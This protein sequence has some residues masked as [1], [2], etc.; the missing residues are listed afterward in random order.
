VPSSSKHEPIMDHEAVVIGA[1]PAGLFSALELAKRKH[2]V[3]ILEEHGKVGEPDHC[4][5]LLSTTGLDRL[6]IH[7]PSHIIQNTVS[8]AKIYSPSGHSIQIERGRNE[9]KVIDRRK[10]DKWLAERAEDV[11]ATITTGARVIELQNQGNTVDSIRIRSERMDQLSAK[12]FIIA[13]GHRCQLSKSVGLPIVKKSY[14]YPAYQY[15]VAG[16]DIDDKIVEMFYGQNIAPGFFAWI[17]PLG[18]RRARIGLAARNKSRP[19]LDNLIQHHPIISE[20]MRGVKIERSMGGVVLIGLPIKK[21]VTGNV[22]VV[23]DTAGVVKATTGGGV[24]L[25]GLT[26]RLAGKMAA[27]ALSTEDLITTL[28]KYD[29]Q[30]KALIGRELRVMY[31]AQHALSS[32]SDKGLDSIIKDA[33]DSGAL[34]IVK[35]A[36][37]MDFQGKVIRGLLKDPRMF[38]IGLRAIR[39]INPFL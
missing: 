3:R 29:R 16:I 30:C 37:D 1:G 12:I 27:D 24:I 13:E 15:E 11:G 14:R 2:D 5:G 23:G 20:R 21:M 34:D 31:L 36:G 18:D 33:G 8:G 28:G 25:G 9:A 7:M 17:I 38:L 22:L 35:D 4:A 6:G 32:L 39:Y 19:R 26:S 10:F